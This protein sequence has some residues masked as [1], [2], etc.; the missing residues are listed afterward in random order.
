MTHPL[1]VGLDVGL[2]TIEAS[3]GIAVGALVIGDIVGTLVPGI[4]VGANLGA[5][6]VRGVDEGTPVEDANGV[7]V[8]V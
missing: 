4:V 6:D 5:C 1:R 3:V 8:D 2:L 7:A